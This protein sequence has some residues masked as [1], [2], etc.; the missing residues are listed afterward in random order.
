MEFGLQQI[1]FRPKPELRLSYKGQAL[2]QH[3]EPDLICFDKIVI[4]L[5]AVSE[6]TNV[7]RAQLQNYLR[8]TEMRL[9]FLVN[10][11]HHPKLEYE[12]IIL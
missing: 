3:Y 12:R 1:P 6:L 7:F 10:F 4:E 2:I 8:L 5:K 11:G 9:G